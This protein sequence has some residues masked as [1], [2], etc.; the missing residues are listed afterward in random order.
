MKKFLVFLLMGLFMIS[1]ASAAEWDN[2]ITNYNEETET[3]T[4]SNGCLFDAGWTCLGSEIGQVQLKTPKN[5]KVAPG[6]NYVWEMDAWV[7]DDYND[8]LKGFEFEDMN[9]NKRKINREIDIKILSYEDVEVD[10][11]EEDCS[12]PKLY[13]DYC[14]KVL[15]GSHMETQEVWTKV[16]P[17]DLKKADGKVTLRGYTDVHDGDYVDWSPLIFGVRVS[18]DIWAAW[19]SSLNVGL[20]Q[21]YYFNETS[22]TDAVNQ[23]GTDGTAINI[24]LGKPG[25]FTDMSSYGFEDDTVVAGSSVDISPPVAPA[26]SVMVSFWLN[27]SD[28]QEWRLFDS[29]DG[30]WK[31]ISFVDSGI[32]LALTQYNGVFGCGGNGATKTTTTIN[33][34]EWHHIVAGLAGG[35]CQIWVDGVL[36]GQIVD[37][38]SYTWTNSGYSGFGG[39]GDASQIMDLAFAGIWNRNLT[40]TEILNLYNEGAPVLIN[41][42]GDAFPTISLNSP[43]SENYTSIQSLDINFTA[44]DN[45]NLTNVSLY[46]NDIINQTNSTGVNNSDYIFPLN[47]GDGNF[48]IKGTA[49]DNNSQTSFSSV[50]Q[51]NIDT[52]SPSIVSALNTSVVYDYGDEVLLNTT[53]TDLNLN[54]C[55]YNY[56]GTNTTIEGCLTGVLNQSA[57]I[58]VE[59]YTGITIYANDTLGNVNST[60]ESFIFDQSGATISVETPTGTIGYGSIGNNE[61]LNVTFTDSNLDSCWYNYNGTNITIDNCL[62]GVKNSTSFLLE[63]GNT[64]MTIYANDTLGNLN[65]TFISWNYNLTLNSQV[66][67][68]TSVES[69]METYSANLSYNSSVFNVITGILYLNG[70][71]YAG[72]RTGSGDSAILSSDVIMPS[73]TE[74][75]N[76]TPYWT[77]SLTDVGG[78]NDY[79]ITLT[80]VSVGVIN[81]SLCD[82]NNDVAFWNFTVLNESNVV[83]INS[84]FEATFA[85]SSIGS[86]ETNTFSFQYT[87]G[88]VSQYDFCLSPSTE[89]YTVSTAIKLTKPGFVDK[90][91]NYQSVTI[92][93][94]TREDNLY[95]LAT[96]DS[97]SYI[98]HVTDTASNDVEEAEV[99]VERFYQGTGIWAVT[100]ILTTNYVGEAVGH[101]LSEDADY[102]FNVSS[103]GVP[104]YN[105][106]AT[107]I[108]CAVTPCTVTLVIPINVVDG[109][110]PLDDLTSTL[111]YSS[112]TNVFTYTYA[113]SSGIFDSARL[114]VLRVWPS[115]ATLL[116]P[117]DETKT[118]V[119]GVITCDITGQLNGTYRASGYITR[120]GTELFDKR[121]DGVLGNRIYNQMGNDGVLWAIFVFMAIIMLGIARPSLAIIFGVIGVILLSVLQ[122]IN[123]GI[124]SVVAITAIAVILLTRVKRE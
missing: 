120:S 18:H 32:H 93:N 114:N 28:N 75:T 113:D 41:G 7:E 116:V 45:A 59:G 108:T 49:V 11:Y 6:Y 121:T 34:G 109:A 51:I 26:S 68:I 98:I 31:M 62:T 47:L 16:T 53:I 84:T 77:V 103:N 115:N 80:N 76:F 22:G 12:L 66:S 105:S 2:A 52:I 74:P 10:N 33:D 54:S 40:E 86:S 21:Y 112:T 73:V 97:T 43:A 89:N 118:T 70:T 65:S 50:I 38:G 92:S 55:W 23:V 39:T 88:N 46:V 44:Y 123:I 117:C 110:G 29:N 56:N 67:P 104:I 64:N 100:E 35:V 17:A 48:T 72:T 95:M 94:A 101:I 3:I 122:I 107:K 14:Q 1:F 58:T 13:G 30:D 24:T 9:N 124:I 82:G 4:F 8:F 91:Y 61:T 81:M 19:E 57:I 85:I 102:R 69:A 79:N 20:L 25:V 119:S 87:D 15:V 90:F 63:S 36:E 111:T 83:E 99:T 96:G 27:T 60:I 78:T 5:F 42:S 106:S 37:A 71:G